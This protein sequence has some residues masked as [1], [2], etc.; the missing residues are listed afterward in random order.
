LLARGAVR[1]R[2]VAVR[3][4]MGASFGRLCRQFLAESTLLAVAGAALG[5]VLAVLGLRALL[6]MAPAGIPRLDGVAID[7]RVLAV[8]LLVSLVVGVAFGVVPALQALRV[9]VIETIRGEGGGRHS[10][11][12]RR[13]RRLREG[14]VVAELALAVTLVLCTG[15]L[16][17]SVGAATAVDPGFRAAGVLKAEYQLPEKRY[18]RDFRTFPRWGEHERFNREL[19]ERVR[20]LPGV[21]GA[22]IAAAH[23]LNAGF[24]NSFV[25][26]G[27]EEEGRDWPEIALR[28]VTP[29]YLSTMGVA[30]TRGRDLEAGDDAAAPR[31]I[32]VNE[33]A[34]SRFFAASDPV[35]QVIRFWG[36]E[37]RV[38]GVVADERFRGLT[39][40]A[41][42]AVYASLAQAPSQSGVLLVRASGEPAALAGAV[43]EAVRGVD[44]ALAVYGVEPLAETLRNSIGDRR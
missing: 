28:L 31:V 11:G 5:C 27:R 42:P 30:L 37:H 41:P 16:L 36:M 1:M 7:A 34:A 38:V 14:L 24:T 15:L 8:T 10:S 17:R 13:G 39:E 35:G 20:G 18:P 25:V 21:E 43:R 26:V 3:E 2:E 12:S 19:L 9:D 6:A 33:A 4:A 22:T 23:P 29:G 44:P 32:L 40:A